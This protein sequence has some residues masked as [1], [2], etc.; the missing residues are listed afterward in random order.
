MA[1]ALPEPFSATWPA[2][3]DCVP[4]A[5]HAVVGYLRDALTPDPPLSDIG[6]AVSEAV[7]NAVTH[8]YVDR[9]PGEVR[10]EVEIGDDQLELVV[11][12]DGGGMLPRPDSPGL[13]L[14]LPLIATVTDRFDTR[15][16]PGEGTRVCMWFRREASAATLN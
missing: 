11:E 6:L 13:G 8:A 2:H 15:S 14:G 7:T 4:V 5:R 10:I 3:V 1:T 9:P 16:Q 12:D